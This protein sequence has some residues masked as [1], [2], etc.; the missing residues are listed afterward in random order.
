[1]ENSL[2][3]ELKEHYAADGAQFEQRVGRYRIDVVN[4]NRL[5][6][7]QLGSLTA[8]RDKVAALVKRHRVL[9]V[10]PI[11]VEKQLIKRKRRGGLVAWR[12]RS[13]KQGCL[14]DLFD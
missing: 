7:I 2:H 1:M 12:R 6:E 10:K 14:L 5:V 11:V 8:I 4:G 3:R 9:V 13:P